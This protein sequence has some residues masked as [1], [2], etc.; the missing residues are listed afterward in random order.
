M[1]EIRDLAAEREWLLRLTTSPGTDRLQ[2]AWERSLLDLPVRARV[3]FHPLPGRAWWVVGARSDRFIVCYRQRA[4]RA[5]GEMEY[6]VVDSRFPYTYNGVGPG[7]VRSSLNTM[8]GGWCIGSDGSG[9]Q[10]ALNELE[11]D[12][13]YELS[14]RRLLAVDMIETA[15]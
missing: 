14:H 11:S 2:D 12:N 13:G 5:Q 6:T 3:R 1:S 8:G 9:C 7:V 4:F 15:P 10:E